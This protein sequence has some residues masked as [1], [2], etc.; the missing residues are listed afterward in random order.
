MPLTPLLPSNNLSDV[1]NAATA[2][3]NLGAAAAVHGHV[4]DDTTGLQVALDGKA[5]SAHTHAISDTTGLQAALDAKAALAGATFTG[6]VGGT[7]VAV[8]TELRFGGSAS[9]DAY[10]KKDAAAGVVQLFSGNDPGDGS[11]G[12]AVFI[13]GAYRLIPAGATIATV[14]VVGVTAGAGTI[15][16]QDAVGAVDARVSNAHGFTLGPSKGLKWGAANGATGYDTGLGRNAAGVVEVNSGTAGTLRDMTMRL[17]RVGTY[18]DLTL[19]TAGT[20]GR[21]AY[22]SDSGQVHDNGTNWRK[23]AGGYTNV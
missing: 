10:F 22:S 7:S 14:N 19:P 12:R 2:R 8:S 16:M 11:V 6:P 15:S 3:G 20:A 21:I 18:T 23:P 5:A 1:D 4:I 13:S 17:L 9:T